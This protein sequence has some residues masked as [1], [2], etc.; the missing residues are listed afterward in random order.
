MYGS[1]TY[2]K[3]S[4]LFRISFICCHILLN[5]FV[6]VCYSEFSGSKAIN[7]FS[8]QLFRE[9]LSEKIVHATTP[10]GNMGHDQDTVPDNVAVEPTFVALLAYIL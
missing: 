4:K 7:S 6:F 5:V 8:I 1:N 10:K 9:R 3:F 2:G